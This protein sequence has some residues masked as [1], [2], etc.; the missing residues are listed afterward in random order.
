MVILA[1]MVIFDHISE[2]IELFREMA[3]E[4]SK[5]KN[6]RKEPLTG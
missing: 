6:R 4:K 1:H 2:D 3:M 5:Q